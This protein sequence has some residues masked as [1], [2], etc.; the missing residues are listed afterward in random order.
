MANEI[1]LLAL[2]LQRINSQIY[3][4]NGEHDWENE[5]QALLFAMK[6]KWENFR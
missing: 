1:N 5:I 6:L 3:Q 4:A 2:K